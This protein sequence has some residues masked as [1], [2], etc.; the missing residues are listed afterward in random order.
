MENRPTPAKKTKK[1]P[2]L[3][4]AQ[5]LGHGASDKRLDILRN[6]HSGGSISEAARA[7]GVSYKAAWQAIDTLSNLAGLPL[8]ERT[9]GGAGGGGARL[10]AGGL[11][12]LEA[13][14]WL[15]ASRAQA[16]DLWSQRVASNSNRQQEAQHSGLVALGLR[17]SMR[18]QCVCQVMAVRKEGGFALVELELPGSGVLSSRVTRESVQLLGLKKSKEVLVLCKATAVTV[19]SE[20]P[21]RTSGT[22]VLHGVVTRA[23]RSAGGEVALQ[24]QGG[25]SLVGFYAGPTRTPKGTAVWAAVDASAVVI[26]LAQG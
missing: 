3:Q 12:L 20:A 1:Q 6:I 22:N 5:A 2:A 21:L 16:L 26:A 15:A 10:S 18:N 23:A 9:V 4:I 13:A 24:L 17:T 19:C 7:A 8:L 25:Q 11:Q 14:D